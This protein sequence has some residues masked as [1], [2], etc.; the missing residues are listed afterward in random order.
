MT[1]GVR[2][3]FVVAAWGGGDGCGQSW[4]PG[5]G[6]GWRVGCGTGIQGQ[7]LYKEEGLSGPSWV[8]DEAWDQ[9]LR[10]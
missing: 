2:V 10:S 6:G 8:E 7:A 4:V 9:M 5:V 1:S 3:G